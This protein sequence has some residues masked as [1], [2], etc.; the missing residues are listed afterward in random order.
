MF[1]AKRILV[2]VDFSMESVLAVEWAVMLAKDDPDATIELCHVISN[3]IAPVG[4]DAI[5]FGYND[6][7]DAQE[8][9]AK[10][11]LEELQSRIP[12]KIFSAYTIAQ[13]SIAAEVARLSQQKGIDMVVMT[14][15]GRRGLSHIL[16][17]STTEETVR[18]A[19]CPVLVLHLNQVMKEAVHAVQSA[20]R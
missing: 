3:V 20:T 14:T 8:K 4:P 19:P 10:R 2:P 18:L 6:V 9:T 12:K 17:G 5:A 1:K 15:Q 11:G 16:Q 7:L 13:G